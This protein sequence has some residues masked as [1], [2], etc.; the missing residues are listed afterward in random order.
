MG[1]VSQL[2]S[3]PDLLFVATRV[4][5][6]PVT[7]HYLR[8]LNILKGLA[9][10]FSVHFFGFRDRE[11]TPAEH[12]LADEA[13]KRICATIH[14]ETVGAEHSKARFLLDLLTSA[15]AL[16][17]VTAARYRSRTMRAA[18]RAALTTH[19]FAIAHADSL[20]S[21]QYLN[22]MTCP[23]LLTN[24]N[25]EHLRLASHAAQ[26]RSL[27]YRVGL[28]SQAWLT[29]RY[30]RR[31]LRTV[32]NCVVVSESDRTELSRLVPSARFF[33]VPN[34]ADTSFPP[35]PAPDPANMT[36]LWVGGMNDPFNREAVLH[37]AS[38]ILPRINDQVVEC[39]WRVVGR[40]PPPELRALAAD[41]HSRIEL[42]GFLPSVREAY[43]Q[44]SIVIV[45]LLSGG[46]TKLKVLEAMAMGRA[47]VTSPVGAEGIRA[48][49]TVDM[50][51]AATDDEFARR[52][53]A[54]L[55]DPA[56]RD[57]IARAGRALA[58]RDYAWEAVNRQMRSVVQC[59][60]ETRSEDARAAACVR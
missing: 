50:E 26:K 32:G 49:D 28:R 23:T 9:E 20:P 13:L 55:R 60:I 40:D 18:I 2:K 57:R 51:I 27:G 14:V 24:H 39:R 7:G 47:V 59:V 15:L 19:R 10:R 11:G 12:N 5:Y 22:G 56:R 3:K 33:V 35:L 46:G 42:A 17:P 31:I 34:G 38:R 4:P 6:P 45:P 25:V 21:G 41:S 37:F 48:R 1:R 30:E 8:T 52:V 36:V 58:E 16:Q 53:V 43:A 44:S 54:L 29:K